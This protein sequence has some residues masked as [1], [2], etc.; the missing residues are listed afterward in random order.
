MRRNYI[1][2]VI[3]MLVVIFGFFLMGDTF[4]IDAELFRLSLYITVLAVLT[5]LYFLIVTSKEK[6]K[7]S[8]KEEL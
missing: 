2:I 6:R 4:F 5:G 1:G 8:K 3:S 7:M